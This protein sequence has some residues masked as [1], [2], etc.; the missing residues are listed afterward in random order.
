MLL[1]IIFSINPDGKLQVTKYGVRF[2]RS[3][4]IL[5]LKLHE[6]STSLAMYHLFQPTLSLPT[7]LQNLLSVE[8]DPDLT[9][10]FHDLT[11]SI[12]KFILHINSK[13]QISLDGFQRIIIFLHDVNQEVL[14]EC[15]EE[16]RHKHNFH[17]VY[18]YCR[19]SH[20]ISE[21]INDFVRLLRDASDN[22]L[23]VKLA[24][25]Q[26]AVKCKAG[27]YPYEE[28]QQQLKDLEGAN[29]VRLTDNL[30]TSFG[31]ICQQIVAFSTHL[32]IV[33]KC[34]KQFKSLKVLTKASCIIIACVFSIVAVYMGD[35]KKLQDIKPNHAWLDMIQ[36]F[37]IAGNQYLK[38]RFDRELQIS[39]FNENVFLL[40]NVKNK[41]TWLTIII[42]KEEEMIAIDKFE[43]KINNMSKTI[44]DMSSH[45][46]KFSHITKEA[47]IIL[48]QLI[49]DGTLEVT[50]F[51]ACFRQGA[52]ILQLKRYEDPLREGVTNLFRTIAFLPA[53]L[54]CYLRAS[55]AEPQITTI[56]SILA[57]TGQDI[58]SDILKTI[59]CFC[60]DLYF[61]VTGHRSTYNVDQD[62]LQRAWKIEV[63]INEMCKFFS[64]SVSFL[65]GIIGTWGCVTLSLEQ[66]LLK[67]RAGE[68]TYDEML[69]QLNHVKVVES[70]ESYDDFIRSFECLCDDVAG[71]LRRMHSVIL[72]GIM[73][74]TRAK[75]KWMELVEGSGQVLSQIIIGSFSI[76]ATFMGDFELLQEME[77]MTSNSTLLLHLIRCFSTKIGRWFDERGCIKKMSYGE[78]LR[79][80]DCYG[81]TILLQDLK[82]KMGGFRSLTKEAE[83]AM[84]TVIHT[85]KRKADAFSNPI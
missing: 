56:K 55:N 48:N 41:L 66:I 23:S 75:L 18:Y 58:S 78:E 85:L 84:M 24:M 52:D 40:Q 71:V 81:N 69:H 74:E 68:Y 20:G 30:V 4:D 34:N 3:E 60:M 28:M 79:V 29:T 12:K 53:S 44:E 25:E 13:Q 39:D 19:M 21:I 54:Q 5:Q 6:S 73:S 33:I 46:H 11:S 8:A 67:C 64:E 7:D 31:H 62:M 9:V 22:W 14:S 16:W 10:F 47:G 49:V 43:K 37:S 76:L 59:R 72:C 61:H 42:R 1:A 83:D 51:G 17:L 15:R 77:N 36:S 2:I 50:E 27:D 57:H 45:A 82:E 63:I 32:F 80:S 65:I 26:I 38:S 70:I 35:D